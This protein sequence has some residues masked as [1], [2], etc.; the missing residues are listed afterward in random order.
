[1]EE[2]LLVVSKEKAGG[3]G[4]FSKG[5]FFSLFFFFFFFFETFFWYFLHHDDE[6]Q[7][8]TPKILYSFEFFAVGIPG[9]PQR[10]SYVV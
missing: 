5:L 4:V 3:L 8:C 7:E 6:T 9:I 2:E 1:M 10:D